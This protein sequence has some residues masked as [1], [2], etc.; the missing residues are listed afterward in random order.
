MFRFYAA[1]GVE[2]P[3]VHVLGG[4]GRAAKV[5]LSPVRLQKAAGY[6]RRQVEEIIKIAEDHSEEWL[7]AWRSFFG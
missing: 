4:R 3:H 7:A 5:W 1:D 6:S 2:P